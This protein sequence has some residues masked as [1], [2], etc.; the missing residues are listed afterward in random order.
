[1]SLISVL[2]S[3]NFYTDVT[4]V[5]IDTNG[6]GQPDQTISINQISQSEVVSSAIKLSAS[7]ILRIFNWTAELFSTGNSII[8]DVFEQA[9]NAGALRF[10]EAE[11]INTSEGPRAPPALVDGELYLSFTKMDS[12]YGLTREG[13][14]LKIDPI[15]LYSHEISHLVGREDPDAALPWDTIQNDP[16]YDYYGGDSIYNSATRFE[17]YVA[18]ILG[19]GEQKRA[20]YV[21]GW[22]TASPYHD[23]I[24]ENID[25]IGY[26]TG[27]LIDQV[28]VGKV[29]EGPSPFFI[30]S[31]GDDLIVTSGRSDRSRELVFG[32]GTEPGFEGDFIQTGDGDDV[33]Y[34][35]DSPD[36]IDAG[37]DDD[38]VFAGGGDDKIIGGTGIDL[39]DGDSDYSPAGDDFG[40]GGDDELTYS[41][42]DFSI[43]VEFGSP[44]R[45]FTD[46][47]VLT[48]SK[49]ARD[50]TSQN[51]GTDTVNGVETVLGSGFA[52]VIV[53]DSNTPLGDW[54][55]V[56]IDLG[57]S[58]D[59]T[60]A[61]GERIVDTVNAENFNGTLTFD[62]KHGDDD[63]LQTVTGGSISINFKN[64]EAAVGGAGSDTFYGGSEGNVFVGNGGFDTVDYSRG[65][66]PIEI[67]YSEEDGEAKINVKDGE[68][69][70]DR[71]ETIEK[72]VGTSGFDLLR[73]VDP[74]TTT[75]L[76]I[77][78]GGGQE[79]SGNGKPREDIING[80]GSTEG[81][82]VNIDQDGN[83]FVSN[84]GGGQIN[85]TGFNTQIVTSAYDDQITDDSSGNK[86]LAGG[87][88]NDIISTSGSSGNVTLVGG[89]GDDTLT[90]GSGNDYLVG[91]KGETDSRGNSESNVLSGGA[92]SDHI[93]SVRRQNI[94]HNS[95]HKLAECWPRLVG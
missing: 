38:W 92:G 87:Q 37:A 68:G 86:R 11:V 88:G 63:G 31:F 80:S 64:V 28:R 29:D 51:V 84:G 6:D 67:N 59:D 49:T 70:T 79:A 23:Y 89:D 3:M 17:H 56:V 20:G 1:M 69:G 55:G 83:G 85:L 65:D 93:V 13:E 5:D 24:D 39:I 81:L 78:G 44:L 50:G 75:N 26:S 2:Q 66:Q 45:P 7:D 14:Y 54:T 61:E 73:I 15:I 47:S 4:S 77:D 43:Q 19:L 30:D 33:I 95:R 35:G 74:I 82:V 52:D 10:A 32:F 25:Y 91:S 46:R 42:A 18:E 12:F 41:G 72:I 40:T 90:G 34:G 60:N 71:L 22:S 27:R 76:T 8:I 62:L 16:E 21:A 94:W 58:G 57:A 36:E 48:V 53:I 9:A